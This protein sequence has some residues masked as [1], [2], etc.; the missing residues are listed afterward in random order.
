MRPSE[1]ARHLRG[2]GL[3]M[4]ELAGVS[5]DPIGDSFSLGRDV[6]VNY[7]SLARHAGQGHALHR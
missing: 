5:Y 6:G 4:K 3:E 2:H 7:M 1:L